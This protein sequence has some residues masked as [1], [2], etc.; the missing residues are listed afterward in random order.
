MNNYLMLMGLLLYV[1]T[2]TSCGSTSTV[3][4]KTAVEKTAVEKEVATE[5]R[6]SALSVTAVSATA[7]LDSTP[8][9]QSTD[10]LTVVPTDRPTVINTPTQ[11]PPKIAS[12]PTPTAS[13]AASNTGIDTEEHGEDAVGSAP[14]PAPIGTVTYY[15]TT[16][17]LPTYPY[18]SYQ[19]DAVDPLLDW[20]YKKF[21]RD[22]FLAEAP[23]P[24]ERDYLAIVIENVYLK[25]TI[26]PELGG[27][28]WQAEHKQSGNR[29]FYQNSVVKPS[30]WGPGNQLGWLAVGG[31]EW[32][33][34][35]IEHGYE[36][37][38][39]WGYIP[40]QHSPELVSVT[41]FTPRAGR[42]INASITISL[43]AGAAS[44]E[45]EPFISNI[46]SDDL[47]FDYWQTAMLAP[48]P[49]NKPSDALHFVLPNDKMILHS[50]GDPTLPEPA[51][52]FSWP[53]YQGRDLSR[54]GNWD[55][56]LGFFEEPQAQGPFVGLYDATYNAGVVRAFPADVVR[57][58][59]VFGL[60][61]NEALSS[62][63]FTDD[64]SY[65]VELHGGLAP[66][67]FEKYR[68]PAGGS[69]SWREV[70]YPIQGLGDL[71]YANEVAAIWLQRT[72]DGLVGGLY[73]TR[74]LDGALVVTAA[75]REISRL[76]IDARPDAPYAGL[77][78]TTT[79]LVDA[80]EL[81]VHFEDSGGYTLLEYNL[82]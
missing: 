64:D 56:Y 12:T 20:P 25:L 75:G 30:P 42:T 9:V 33:L 21:D 54:L 23:Q 15:K 55:Q 13:A 77:L 24:T 45:I 17:T 28:L 5:E 43:R 46:G 49:G 57:G 39:P 40:N 26:L 18:E 80:T 69:V 65:Y 59:K 81:K 79:Q 72:D 63:N 37:G 58:S 8:T 61:W 22:R 14:A 6:T 38:T 7:V 74:P 50:S 27:R 47:E 1:I 53:V 62:S 51:G 3:V 44:F 29:I 10:M 11:P 36:W 52:A 78:A 76:Q 68:L 71:T 82:Q 31:L 70:W 67:F 19:S 32:N 60:G 35:V 2:L 48:G 66:N 41:V 4:E 34:P 73:P 16:V